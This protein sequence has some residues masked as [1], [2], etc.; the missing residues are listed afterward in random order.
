MASQAQGRLP[1]GGE[2][3][4][5]QADSMQF[6]VGLVA[7]RGSGLAVGGMKRREEVQIGDIMC[8]KTLC[9]L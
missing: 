7:L 8:V 1:G 3:V 5:D 6:R 4:T 2:V 9:K